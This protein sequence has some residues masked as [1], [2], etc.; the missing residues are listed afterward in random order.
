MPGIKKEQFTPGSQLPSLRKSNSS[1]ANQKSIASFFQKK[2]IEPSQT[3]VKV[4][5]VNFDSVTKTIT[6]SNGTHSKQPFLGSS[7]SLTPAPSSD[8]VE[9]GDSPIRN[10]PNTAKA[11][12]SQNNGLPSP[13]TPVNERTYEAKP[14]IN[15]TSLTLNFDSPSRKVS[16][17]SLGPST[18]RILL[19]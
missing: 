4:T 5:T 16:L 11:L 8:A 12:E 7:S 14:K 9:Q 18:T 10:Q 6:S 13:I 1:S 17:R 2:P 19:N 3:E 15:G